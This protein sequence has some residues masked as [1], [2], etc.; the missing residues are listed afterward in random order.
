MGGAPSNGYLPRCRLT[1]RRRFFS[2]LDLSGD[3]HGR[4]KWLAGIPL[5]PRMHLVACS[6]H[7]RLL[8]N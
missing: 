1:M 4:V 8:N 6:R 2:G 5:N 3:L 7:D